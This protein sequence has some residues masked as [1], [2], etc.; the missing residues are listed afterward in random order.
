MGVTGLPGMGTGSGSHRR[1]G[2]PG[3]GDRPWAI[4]GGGDLAGAG[5]GVRP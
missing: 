5:Y 4:T 3:N 1:K 2:L